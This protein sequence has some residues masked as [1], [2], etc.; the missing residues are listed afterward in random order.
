MTDAPPPP[1]RATRADFIL[2][3]VGREIARAGDYLH[4][5]QVLRDFTAALPALEGDGQIDQVVLR[6]WKPD[7]TF[8]GATAMTLTPPSVLAGPGYDRGD[9]EAGG[10]LPDLA[11]CT[12]QVAVHRYGEPAVAVQ[13]DPWDRA[14]RAALDSAADVVLFEGRYLPRAETV[15][16]LVYREHDRDELA[17]ARVLE[18]AHGR[19][20]VVD[21]ID[22]RLRQLEQPK[23]P[24][25]VA[26]LGL[27]PLLALATWASPELPAHQ[28][29][30]PVPRR[31]R[32]AGCGAP[33]CLDGYTA[34]GTCTT[35][36]GMGADHQVR[37]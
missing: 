3:T 30:P 25:S 14:N 6:W 4:H 5:Q 36:R 1:P 34:D 31:P 10:K 37:E 8:L 18:L 33:G 17:R 22:H 19:L 24:R 11:R 35:C 23:A 32:A 21:A 20:E 27:L 16:D 2:A 28:R 9:Y 29:P 7:G 15:I 12:L 26:A 13:G